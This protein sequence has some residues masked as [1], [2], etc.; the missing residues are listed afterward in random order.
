MAAF[1]NWW[2]SVRDKCFLEPLLTYFHR[3]IDENSG[4]ST[5]PT[6]SSKRS[7]PPKLIVALQLGICFIPISPL[8]CCLKLYLDV[9]VSFLVVIVDLNDVADPSPTHVQVN[10]KRTHSATLVIKEPVALAT[11]PKKDEPSQSKVCSPLSFFA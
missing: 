7:R 10:R 1:L 4:N 5:M 3:V 11:S 8:C 6:A 9:L 2:S